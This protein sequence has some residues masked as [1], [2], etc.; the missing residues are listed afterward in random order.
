MLLNGLTN[1]QE[2]MEIC[3]YSSPIINA[4]YNSNFKKINKDLSKIGLSNSQINELYKLFSNIYSNS[5]FEKK[6]HSFLDTIPIQKIAE[7]YIIIE[8]FFQ[9][10]ASSFDNA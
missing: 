6:L 9:M 3:G 8:K 10:Q 2:L 7:L 5:D 4:L 1:Y